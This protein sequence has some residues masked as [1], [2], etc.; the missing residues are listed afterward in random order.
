MSTKTI[1]LLTVWGSTLPLMLDAQLPASTQTPAVRR[2]AADLRPLADQLLPG[3]TIVEFVTNATDERVLPEHPLSRQQSLEVAVAEA[4]QVLLVELQAA[5]ASLFNQGRWIV[6][7]LD[8]KV[9]EVMKASQASRVAAGS[10]V[11]FRISGGELQINGVLVRIGTKDYEVGQNYLVFLKSQADS[12]RSIT[13]TVQGPSPRLVEGDRLKPVP[14][15]QEDIDGFTLA[16][17][18]RVAGKKR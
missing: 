11:S 18:R 9:I 13:S 3:D 15:R 5:D 16:D 8:C 2:A 17:V 7:R 10:H 12:A 1:I 14:G 6:R 4:E